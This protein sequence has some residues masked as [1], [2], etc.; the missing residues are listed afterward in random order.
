MRDLRF[1]GARRPCDFAHQSKPPTPKQET[2]AVLPEKRA[3]SSRGFGIDG[4]V[5][6]RRTAENADR[7]RVLFRTDIGGIRVREKPE[8]GCLAAVRIAA[9]HMNT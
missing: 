2:I 1:G 6:R 9:G 5:T 7:R 8:L 4:I 3:Q